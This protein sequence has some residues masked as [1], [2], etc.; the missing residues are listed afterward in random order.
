MKRNLKLIITI[1]SLFI[2]TVGF[3]QLTQPGGGDGSGPTD[4]GIAGGGAPVGSGLVLVIGL[5]LA[6]GT[7]KTYQLTQDKE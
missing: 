6:Y 7:R 1:I 5:G 3:A 2:G 4:G